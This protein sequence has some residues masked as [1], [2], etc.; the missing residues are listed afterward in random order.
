MQLTEEQKETV[1][2]WVRAGAGLSDVQK[3]LAAELNVAMTYMDVRFLVLE[4]G[5]DLRDK[6]SSFK[7]PAAPTAEKTRPA[8]AQD[9]FEDDGADDLPE[10]APS[11]GRVKVAVDRI[12]KAGAVA[13]GTVTFSDGVNGTWSVDSFGRLALAATPGYAPSKADIGEFQVALRNAL[14]RGGF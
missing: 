13:S 11:S 1:K 9:D 14:S 8:A 5:L 12:M 7:A 2:Q 3:R 6:P 4:L 10:A